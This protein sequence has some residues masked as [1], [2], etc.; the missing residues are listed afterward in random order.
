MK[1]IIIESP[2]K[3]HSFREALGKE[4][5]IIA[6]KGHVLDLPPKKFSVDIKKDFQ[7]TFEVIEG[8]ENILEDIRQKAKKADV[9]YIMSDG[10]TEGAGLGR[11]IYNEIKDSTKAIIFR[12]ETN[13][14]TKKGILEGIKNAY[15]IEQNQNKYNAYLT[16]RILDRVAGY[17]GSWPVQSATGGKSAGRV[18]SAIL[19]V[20]VDREKEI[21]HFVPEEYWILTAHLLNSKKE[22]FFGTLESPKIKNQLEAEKI[23]NLVKVGSPVISDIEKKE[24]D[25]RAYAPFTTLPLIASASSVYGW[26]AEKTMKIA[27]HLFENSMITYH[28]SDC[29]TISA[30]ALSSVRSFISTTYGEKYLPQKANYYASKKGAQEAHEAIRPTNVE[31][32]HPPIAGDELKLYTLIWKRFVASQMNPGRDEKIKVI[33]K[34]ANYDFISRGSRILFDGFRKVWDYGNNEDVLLPELHKGEKCTF[35][36]SPSKEYEKLFITSFDG[37]VAEQKFT[38]PPSRYSDASLSKKC[39]AEQIAR[40]ATFGSF[41]KLLQDRGYIVREKKSFIPTPLGIRVVDFLVAA[42]VCFVDLK[43]TASLEEKLDLIQE[44]KLDKLDVL[45]EF[46]ERLKGDLEKAKTVKSQNE[47]TQFVCPK[48]GGKLKL[49]NSN[50]GGFFSCENYKKVKGEITGCSY[51]AKCVDGQP[52]EKEPPKEKEYAPFVCK[53]CGGK[54]V[55]RTAKKT[56]ESF[57]GCNSFPACR[58]TASLDGTFKE[59]TTNPVKKKFWKKK[60]K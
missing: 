20:L 48:C 39:E 50:W 26:G 38:S 3:I 14:I 44:E 58:C 52:V 23:Y 11:N 19:R 40:P 49:K 51:T 2:N 25:V 28:R 54:M 8:K 15:P 45:K 33:T 43:F 22:S 55:K 29:T 7:P 57:W 59:K 18:Q 31:N 1:L 5:E 16:R 56:G 34:I 37:L 42:D 6:S 21:V 27:Q 60:K 46:W 9:V 32:Q 4:Y 17:K 12:A 53:E 13:E 47:E 24:I 36:K 41:L 10:D 30:D 35:G